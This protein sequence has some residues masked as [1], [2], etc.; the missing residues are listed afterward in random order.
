MA[1]SWT[2]AGTPPT[3][4]NQPS[5]VT[6][7]DGATFCISTSTGNLVPG[8]PMGLFVHDARVLATWEVRIDHGALE[9]LA[10]LSDGPL[11]ATFISRA[12]PRPG[13]PE[14]T[15]LITREREV[16]DG[17]T[18]TITI[19]NLANEAAGLTV[20]LVAGTD[21][22]DLFEVKEGRSRMA[23]DI[24]SDVVDGALLLRRERDGH[25]RG[26]RVVA[27]T[28][29][30]T[31]P[32]LASGR[33]TW[34]CVVGPRSEWSAKVVVEALVDD[35]SV[36]ST[37]QIEATGAASTTR[38]REWRIG[39]P[40]MS[41]PDA[42]LSRTLARSLEDLG[43]LRMRDPK[44]PDR[45]GVAAG[46]PWFMATFGRDS[47]LT[48]W[49]LLPIDL[50]LA[51]GVLQTLAETQGTRDDPF[52][53]EQ[54][55]RILHELRR[56]PDSSFPLGSNG[57]YYGSIDSTPLFVMLLGELRR[58]G[59]APE[60]VDAMLPNADRAL[61]WIVE[62]GDRDG[63]GFVEYQRSSDRGLR[64]QGWKDS[65]DAIT[66]ADGT[67]AEPPIALAEV[68][69]Y[70]YA[71]YLARAHFAVETGDHELARQ[72]AER[73]LRL[74]DAFNEAFWLP[75]R[76]Y[77]ALALD[78]NKRP[79]DALASNMGHC[80]WTGIIDEAR[81]ESVA[82]HL[83]SPEMFSGWGIR[84]LASSMAAY[85]PMSYHNGSVWPH[86][87]A[88][89]AAGLSRYGYVAEAERVAVGLL[90]AAD[91]LGG[92]LPELICGMSRDDFARPIGYPT[93]CAPQAWAA[94][95]PFLLLR[96]FLRLEP[97]IPFGE[98]RLAPV[99]PPS[100]L[101][102]HVSNLSLGGR[103]VTIDM[104]VDGFSVEGLS[105]DLAIVAE[106]RFAMT[107]LTAG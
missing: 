86:D 52:T 49:M 85:N 32:G 102:L 64:N 68:Q 55:G 20:E 42:G 77:Y 30:G 94:A 33:M 41:T 54:P 65:G 95:S 18:E 99:V 19:R 51:L 28:S 57:A 92:Q 107:L 48:S 60:D 84:T 34:Q 8:A 75:D 79:V 56:G 37:A 74:K 27:S 3:I 2:F 100:Y 44:N 14:S 17:M 96:T 104:T 82:A 101:P 80:L 93:A 7:V 59:Q 16:G 22:A 81:A 61:A 12:R 9:P 25:S 72:W 106:P 97:R 13:R 73:A 39:A 38:F 98:V 76:G 87:N 26:T 24:V 66:F 40:V 4:D 1:E 70:T 10:V 91:M 36:A 103:R 23:E 67:V 69:G 35:R 50:R 83:M 6:L 89:I 43:A 62:R 5:L 63:D 90:D 88:I 31:A 21:F 58:W 29:G 71:A 105:P 15:I 11:A 78:R 45:V 46:A 53:E 47:L